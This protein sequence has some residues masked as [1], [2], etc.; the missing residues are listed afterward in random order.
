MAFTTWPATPRNGWGIGTIVN[1]MRRAQT[2]TPL[3]QQRGE[4]IDS[5]RFPGLISQWHCDHQLEFRRSRFSGSCDW[6]SLRNG[7]RK[8]GAIPSLT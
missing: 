4:E 2:R 7:C 1:I 5:W 3:V 8:I 6:V